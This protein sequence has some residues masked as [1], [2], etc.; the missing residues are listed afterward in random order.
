MIRT[1][2]TPHGWCVSDNGTWLPG[3]YDSKRTA[4][5]ASEYTDE[6]LGELLSICSVDG[7]NRPITMRDLEEA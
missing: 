3:V 6:V 2:K 5:S 7:P 1:Y 4:L